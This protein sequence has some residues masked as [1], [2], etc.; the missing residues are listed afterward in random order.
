[1]EEA[2]TMFL[3]CKP[4][5]EHFVDPARNVSWCYE[6][7]CLKYEV[8]LDRKAKTVNVSGDF[9]HPFSATSLFE[10]C[11][12][13]DRVAIETEPLFYGDKKIL[14]FRKDYECHKDFKCLMIMRWENGEL[15]VW[16]SVYDASQSAL[17][18]WD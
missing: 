7:K 6:G 10:I 18:A 3:G 8:I 15:S 4:Q 16:P 14:V 1:M 12:L 5:A 2:I 11:I 17:K 13:F 9:V